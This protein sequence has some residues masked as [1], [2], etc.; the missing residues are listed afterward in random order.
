MVCVSLLVGWVG[1]ASSHLISSHLI[2][3]HLITS[4]IITSFEHSLTAAVAKQDRADAMKWGD[5]LL[6]A[7]ADLDSLLGC[8][9]VRTVCIVSRSCACP[10]L[11][12]LHTVAP[13]TYC[14]YP[15]ACHSCSSWAGVSHWLQCVY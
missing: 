12:H 5:L 9:T 1:G 14:T 7:Y 11:H 13:L 8:D 2:S 15:S 6:A 3:S 4:Q 10:P